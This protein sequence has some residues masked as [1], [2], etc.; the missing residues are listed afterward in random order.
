MEIMSN[1]E[2]IVDNKMCKASQFLIKLLPFNCRFD[3]YQ[4]YN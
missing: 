4:I 1:F 2:L 3:S